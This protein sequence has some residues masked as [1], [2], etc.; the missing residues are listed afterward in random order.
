MHK[1]I[2][3]QLYSCCDIEKCPLYNTEWFMC[4]IMDNP[5]PK[6]WDDE[7]FIT[8]YDYPDDC[9]AKIGVFVRVGKAT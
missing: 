1:F 6:T 9:P 3:K 4:N 5:C 8:H 2:L 7:N